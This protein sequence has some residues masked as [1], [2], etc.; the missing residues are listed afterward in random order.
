MEER[1]LTVDRKTYELES[2]FM[3]IATQNPVEMAGTYPLPEAQRDRFTARISMG[4]PPV[5][6][7][8]DM[9]DEPSASSPLDDL[10]PVADAEEARALIQTVRK[11]HISAPLAPQR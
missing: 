1:Q 8:L 6:A 2:P 3:V 4:Y 7:E 10:I 11:V 5:S 9:L